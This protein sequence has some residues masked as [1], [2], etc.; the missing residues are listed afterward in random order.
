[1]R[2]RPG[3][4]YRNESIGSLKL[5]SFDRLLHCFPRGHL[6]SL[7]GTWFYVMIVPD[8]ND[9]TNIAIGGEIVS[10]IMVQDCSCERETAVR[11]QFICNLRYVV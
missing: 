5:I 4:V 9:S 1:M 3:H 11:V 10:S 6:F 7:H 8:Q 2:D